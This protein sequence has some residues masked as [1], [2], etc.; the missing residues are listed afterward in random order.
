MFTDLIKL[1]QST[2]QTGMEILPDSLAGLLGGQDFRAPGGRP[3]APKVAMFV[4]IMNFFPGV[5]NL[6]ARTLREME[7][8]DTLIQSPA[9][10]ISALQDLTIPGPAGRIPIRVYTPNSPTSKLGSAVSLPALVFYH[11]AGWVSG[12]L[13]SH[14]NLCK[15][16][17]A[18]SGCLVVAVDFRLAPEHKFPA[19]LEDALTAY[20]WVRANA[21]SIGADAA[22]IAVGG[23]STGGNLAAAVSLLARDKGN[24]PDYQLLMYPLLD[25]SRQTASRQAFD[26]YGMPMGMLDWCA[27]QY[28]NSPAEN[29]RFEASPIRA[30]D[31][32]GLPE[33]HIICGDFDP[34]I[35]ECAAYVDR[36]KAANVKVRFSR[37]ENMIH[38]FIMLSALFADSRTAADDAAL[39]M[40][41]FFAKFA[42]SNPPET[43]GPVPGENIV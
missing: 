36:L 21:D 34:V 25:L 14:D 7:D 10:D 22:R 40:K 17:A 11:G 19:G 38:S 31:L 2:V 4:R 15:S 30:A 1:A 42:R 5:E 29:T 41:R 9:P 27:G 13:H 33:T 39:Q 43:A 37:Y 12:G 26:G 18:K 16:L 23:E 6:S 35:D 24:T 3:L 20:E 28:L 32:T 8:M